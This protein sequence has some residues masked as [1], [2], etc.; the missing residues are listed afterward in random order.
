METGRCS[1]DEALID[2][3]LALGA[4][5]AVI[6]SVAVI[7]AEDHFPEFCKPPGCNNY[8]LSA[9]CPPHVM[10]PAGFRQRLNEYDRALVFRIDTP[11]EILLADERTDVTRLLQETTAALERMAADAGYGKPW[12][13]ACGCCK[14]LFC[15]EHETCSVLDGDKCRNPDKARV[16]MSGLG[17]NF[18]ILGRSLGWNSREVPSGDAA[19]DE[20]MGMLVGIILLG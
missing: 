6:V 3:A 8:G 7:R 2:S 5:D 4:D 10:K 12:G 15:P 20:P 19:G 13:I 16:S 18:N 17:V 1:K 11:M 14:R 9:N